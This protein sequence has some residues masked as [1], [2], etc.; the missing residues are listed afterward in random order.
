MRR[1]VASSGMAAPDPQEGSAPQL[2]WTGHLANAH[3][4]TPKMDFMDVAFQMIGTAKK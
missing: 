4:P 1:G 3:A 2:G